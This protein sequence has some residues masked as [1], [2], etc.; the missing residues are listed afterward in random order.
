MIFKLNILKNS[1]GAA[2]KKQQTN[3]NSLCET[4]F[5]S[6]SINFIFYEIMECKIL[7]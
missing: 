2:K 5:F 6:L 1:A 7:L 3:R 4:F